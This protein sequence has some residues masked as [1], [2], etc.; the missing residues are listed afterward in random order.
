MGKRAAF[1]KEMM[2]KVETHKFDKYFNNW[3]DPQV[4]RKFT[5]KRSKK[6]EK[7]WK[8]TYEFRYTKQ[9]KKYGDAL[10]TINYKKNVCR[11]DC[12]KLVSDQKSLI[13]L[14]LLF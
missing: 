11:K 10:A 13:K 14:T 8:K 3:I 7:L 4:L 6:N 12:H 1:N 9:M 5:S 2:E